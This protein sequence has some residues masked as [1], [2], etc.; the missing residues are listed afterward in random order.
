MV[1]QELGL[2]SNVPT[3]F[4]QKSY[5]E[6]FNFRYQKSTFSTSTCIGDPDFYVAILDESC[7]DHDTDAGSD[8]RR[9][10]TAG[11]R[12]TYNNNYYSYQ[13]GVQQCEGPLVTYLQYS[14]NLCA[15]EASTGLYTTYTCS[16][17]CFHE[18]TVITYRGQKLT[19]AS[20]QQNPLSQL[21]AVPHVVITD[22]VKISTSCKTS[23]RLSNTHLVYTSKGLV[24]AVDVQLGDHL[25][26]DM[27]QNTPC[28]VLSIEQEIKQKYFGLNCEDS[29]VLADGYKTSTFG[30][31][32]TI[33]AAWMKYGSL[34]LGV[35]TASAIGDLVASLFYAY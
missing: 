12:G 24:R 16:P 9:C 35:H 8:R 21:C 4:W 31:Y 1:N 27:E 23:L 18:S 14:Q 34:V 19:L 28:Q 20:L 11:R 33:P 22:G 10:G 30:D 29:D 25:F 2:A 32:H 17:P 15:L 26:A 5:P 7:L 13:Y 3:S 6:S